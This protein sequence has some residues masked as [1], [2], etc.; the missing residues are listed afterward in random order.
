MISFGI[1]FAY[2]TIVF[3]LNHIN[4]FITIVYHGMFDIIITNEKFDNIHCKYILFLFLIIIS[5]I[6]LLVLN[7]KYE[8]PDGYLYIYI[9]LIFILIKYHTNVYKSLHIYT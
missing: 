6:G 1:L 3:S 4:K 8:T 9:L 7:D 5:N 2:R